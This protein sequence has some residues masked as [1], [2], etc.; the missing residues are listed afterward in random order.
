M[1][2]F[3][4]LVVLVGLVTYAIVHFS[5]K[6]QNVEPRYPFFVDSGDL[7]G[8]QCKAIR[9][10]ARQRMLTLSHDRLVDMLS[11]VADDSPKPAY[12]W[13]EMIDDDPDRV[14]RILRFDPY[15]ILYDIT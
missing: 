11:A 14:C 2:L 12:W 10:A 5:Q 8:D 9:A 4:L 13:L 3:V 7:T 1:L 15:A 6:R